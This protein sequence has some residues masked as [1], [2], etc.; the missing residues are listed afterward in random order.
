M[1]GG[2]DRW[3]TFGVER[4]REEPW[5]DKGSA[6]HCG[7]LVSTSCWL[8]AVLLSGDVFGRCWKI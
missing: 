1:S 7:D 8:L 4:E 2:A 6:R 5:V 3:D